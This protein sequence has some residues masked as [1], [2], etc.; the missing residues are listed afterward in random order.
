MKIGLITVVIIC[1]NDNKL[2]ENKIE[3][4]SSV[5]SAGSDDKQTIDNTIETVWLN[6]HLQRLVYVFANAHY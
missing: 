3:G 1:F 5:D 2:R 4:V 6:L